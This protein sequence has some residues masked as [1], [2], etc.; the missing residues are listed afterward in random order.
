ME[1]SLT[2]TT[3]RRTQT[4]N[5]LEDVLLAQT[6][7]AQTARDCADRERERAQQAIERAEIAQNNEAWWRNIY[8]QVRVAHEMH[9]LVELTNTPHN[10]LRR[11]TGCVH[12]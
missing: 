6:Q 4:V 10:R 3:S 5:G 11:T 9:L 12:K 8:Y 7:H 1:D 2:L